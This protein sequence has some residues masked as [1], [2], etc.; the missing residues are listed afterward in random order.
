MI[1]KYSFGHPLET[2]A[3][4]QSAA[5]S[6]QPF[7]LMQL[8]QSESGIQLS[9]RMDDEDVVYGL[10]E[11]VRGINKRGFSYVSY[12]TDDPFHLENKHSLYGAHNFLILSRKNGGSFGIFVDDPGRVVFDR[13]NA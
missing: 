11:Q 3:V 1:K 13:L 12:A 10:G 4:V 9:C 5:Q 8:I 6:A 7:H 2:G